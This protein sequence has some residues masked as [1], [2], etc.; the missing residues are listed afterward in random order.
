MSG[1]MAIAVVVGVEI[2][3]GVDDDLRSLG[4]GGVIEVDEWVVVFEPAGEDGEVG[5]AIGDVSRRGGDWVCL[6][7]LLGVS[8]AAESG[9]VEEGRRRMV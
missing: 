9:G 4:G 3:V 6:D 2:L 7:R 5:A 1:A 8:R